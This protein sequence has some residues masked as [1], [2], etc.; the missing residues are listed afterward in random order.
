MVRLSQSGQ[1]T[2]RNICMCHKGFHA[3]NAMAVCNAHLSFINIVCRWHRSVHDSAIFNTSILHAH[4]L[5]GGCGRN[6][7]LL[8][9]RGYGIQLYLLTP[10]RPENVT[11][12]VPQRRYQKAILK[13][14]TPSRG[15]LVS[16]R[17]GFAV[18]CASQYVCV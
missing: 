6:G 8:G 9:D 11:I 5:E 10:F 2:K 3:I 14:V 7:W 15:P 17:P 16:G 18:C 13:L 1:H 12:I 4:N